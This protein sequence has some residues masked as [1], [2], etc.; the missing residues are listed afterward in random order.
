MVCAAGVELAAKP[1]L[2]FADEPTSGLDGQSAFKVV[3]FLRKLADLGQSVLVTV[4]QPSAALFA[5]FDTLLLLKAGGKVDLVQ[6]FLRLLA[7]EALL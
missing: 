3:K 2:L 5:E 4:H 7:V 6:C 1:R